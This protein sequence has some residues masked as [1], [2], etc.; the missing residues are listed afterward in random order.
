M[1]TIYQFLHEWAFVGL[2]IC[3]I[4]LVI[5]GI[6]QIR[7]NKSKL[8]DEEFPVSDEP[9]DDASKEQTE[10]VFAEEVAK[11]EEPPLMQ[12]RCFYQKQALPSPTDMIL[13][14]FPDLAPQSEEQLEIFRKEWKTLGGK[15]Q[16]THSEKTR[17]AAI[18]HILTVFEPRKS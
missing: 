2:L 17:Y 9:E 1:E 12:S 15:A 16:M 10:E 8:K 18:G 11:V 6:W 3:I 13:R 7:A 4:V 5:W 14:E